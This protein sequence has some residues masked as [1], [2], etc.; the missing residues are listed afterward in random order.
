MR[1]LAIAAALATTMLASPA[2]ARDGTTYA[3]IEGGLMLVEDTE[4]DYLDIDGP[5]GIN[6]DYDRGV[7][8]DVIVGHDF[9]MFRLEGELGWKRAG[10]DHVQFESTPD[11]DVDDLTDGNVR[12]LSAMGNALLDFEEGG[13][14]G[15]AGGGLG[16]ANVRYRLDG[17]SDTDSGLAWQLIAGVSTAVSPNIDLGLKYRFFN[18]K[19]LEF[20]DSRLDNGRF[21]SHSLLASLIFNFAPP[22]APIVPVVEAPPPPPPPATQTCPDGSVILATD[23]CPVPPPPPPPPPPEPERG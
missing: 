10:I 15:Y 12:V 13:L 2:V 1:K 23:T 5:M 4:F 6:I 9:G 16:F 19:N 21:R 14:R 8:A 17:T 22:P 18:A 20:S 3:G 7:D 11:V